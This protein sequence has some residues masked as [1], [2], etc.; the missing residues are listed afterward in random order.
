MQLIQLKKA[1]EFYKF[2]CCSLCDLLVYFFFYETHWLKF[3][4]VPVFISGFLSPI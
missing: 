4:A 1:N 3:N 2:N